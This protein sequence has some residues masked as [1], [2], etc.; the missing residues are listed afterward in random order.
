ML[1]YGNIG[2]FSYSEGT[3]NYNEKSSNHFFT[4]LQLVVYVSF[5]LYNTKM[6]EY[7]VP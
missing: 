2:V 6:K 7:D 3:H 5:I 4:S 1:K